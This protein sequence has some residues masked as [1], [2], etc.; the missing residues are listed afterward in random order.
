MSEKDK[1]T[2]ASKVELTD[3]QLDGAEGGA[4]YLKLGDIEGES[5]WK[6]NGFDGKGNDIASQAYKLDVLRD[7]DTAKMLKSSKSWKW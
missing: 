2:E 3:E 7:L 4:G 6:V 1:T 5:S